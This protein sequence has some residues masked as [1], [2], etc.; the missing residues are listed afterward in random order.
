[1]DQCIANSYFQFVQSTQWCH[2]KLC[3]GRM[4]DLRRQKLRMQ[5]CVS[6]HH[7]NRSAMITQVHLQQKRTNWNRKC[8]DP[9]VR[10]TTRDERSVFCLGSKTRSSTFEHCQ[11]MR[12]VATVMRMNRSGRQS[13]WVSCSVWIVAALIGELTFARTKARS[14]SSC[15]LTEVSG[16]AFRKCAR[17]IWTLGIWRPYWWCPHWAI[18]RSTESTKHRY[19]MASR[20]PMQRPTRKYSSQPVSGMMGFSDE[21]W[22]HSYSVSELHAEHSSKRNTSRKRSYVR[23][24]PP[25]RCR[26]FLELSNEPPSVKVPPPYPMIPMKRHPRITT[27]TIIIKCHPSTSSPFWI[28][29]SIRV[30]HL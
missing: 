14:W 27:T 24:H 21:V 9:S 17:C 8:K 7:P 20:N 12:S 2:T 26:S 22:K 4:F 30:H 3:F 19:P 5:W 10:E 16:W 6:S 1:M 25:V 13:I 11:A 28:V 18:P 23:C 29:H 15:F